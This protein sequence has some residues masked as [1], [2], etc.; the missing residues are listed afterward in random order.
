MI[1]GWLWAGGFSALVRVWYGQLNGD[2]EGSDGLL[3]GLEQDGAGQLKGELKYS[4]RK[5]WMT[6]FLEGTVQV[7]LH[8]RFSVKVLTVLVPHSQTSVVPSRASCV[9]PR[10]GA[11]RRCGLDSV[12][13]RAK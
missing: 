9:A 8:S 5:T 4:T 7:G 3:G 1:R 6:M 12:V 10:L 11:H 13:T 2:M